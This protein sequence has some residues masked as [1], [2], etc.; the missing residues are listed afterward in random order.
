[1]FFRVPRPAHSHRRTVVKQELADVRRSHR[2]DVERN[3]Y[4]SQG[5]Q[6]YKI[7]ATSLLEKLSIKSIFNVHTVLASFPAT[8][9]RV[10][11]EV[12]ETKYGSREAQQGASVHVGQDV[13]DASW[14]SCS[15]AA[16]ASFAPQQTTVPRLVRS[17]SGKTPP[18]GHG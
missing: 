1:M 12:Y 5:E 17:K 2:L 10:S 15:R 7:S 4:E 8:M 16:Q 13:E 9:F 14:S 18:S 3:A 6:I 11:P